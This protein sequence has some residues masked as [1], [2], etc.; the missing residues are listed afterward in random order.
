MKCSPLF[1]RFLQLFYTLK[2]RFTAEWTSFEV[3]FIPYH[4]FP[5]P[6][7][8]TLDGNTRGFKKRCSGMWS[9]W[10]APPDAKC[11]HECGL[12][13]KQVVQERSCSPEDC[14]CVWVSKSFPPKNQTPW[15][16]IFYGKKLNTSTRKLCEKLNWA[17]EILAGILSSSLL[18]S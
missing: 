4:V 2:K 7:D 6:V 18:A 1:K 15:T 8:R 9:E 16:Y 3:P 12:C 14:D 13:G 17:V 5:K 11:S 10:R